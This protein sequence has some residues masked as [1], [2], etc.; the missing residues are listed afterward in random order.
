MS[1]E[2][3]NGLEAV[4]TR[5]RKL[6][7]FASDGRG[8]E[9]EMGNAAALANKLIEEYNLSMASIEAAGGS[10]DN[11]RE[12]GIHNE[13]AQYKWMQTLMTGIASLHFCHLAKRSAWKNGK[14]VFV[15]YQLIGRKANVATAT[16]MYEYLTTTID[17]IVRETLV[18]PR[19]LQS[20]VANSMRTGMADRLC[21]RLQLRRE[22]EIEASKARAEAAKA[23]HQHKPNSK[24]AVVVVLSDFVQDE[25]D[26]NNDFRNGYAPGTTRAR[27]LAANARWA[28]QDAKIKA[29]MAEGLSYDAA[30]D[31]VVGGLTREEAE[32]KNKPATAAQKKKDAEKWARYWAK[33]ER[34]REREAARFDGAAYHRGRRMGDEI[35][36]D[37]QVDQ[38]ARRSIG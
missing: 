19:Q 12:K 24:N 1:A 14:T 18:D 35:G 5:I 6:L 32:K 20:K 9:A 33:Q 11:T 25:E 31:M 17:R 15:G 3:N 38:K 10:T 8:N 4:I 37:V 21:E 29:L 7:A 16:I 28:D 36:L 30:W 26:A 2:T 13:T 34:A 23:S 27:R 22:D